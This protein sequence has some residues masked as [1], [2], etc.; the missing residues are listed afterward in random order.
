M[1]RIYSWVA[2]DNLNHSKGN[3][4]AILT[5]SQ[6]SILEIQWLIDHVHLAVKHIYH[7]NPEVVLYTDASGTSWGA[8]TDSGFSTNGIWS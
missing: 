6:G 5:L 7:S 8:K 4:D 1:L 3:Y 2:R